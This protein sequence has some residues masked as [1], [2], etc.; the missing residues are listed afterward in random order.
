MLI[1]T[2]LFEDSEW[3]VYPRTKTTSYLK[4]YLKSQN[5]LS[6]VYH[7]S[8]KIQSK[9]LYKVILYKGYKLIKCSNKNNLGVS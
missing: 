1:F 7:Q 8:M 5:I 9:E 3:V 6:Y 4:S 2:K